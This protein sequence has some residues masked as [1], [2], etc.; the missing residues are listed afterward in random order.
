MMRLESKG[1]GDKKGE[2]EEGQGRYMRYARKGGRAETLPA[3]PPQG[4]GKKKGGG[5]PGL[6]LPYLF[7]GVELEIK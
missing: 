1:G 4:K 2:E 3:C 5:V 6:P 7:G